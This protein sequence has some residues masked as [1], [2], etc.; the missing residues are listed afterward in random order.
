M[1]IGLKTMLGSVE[2][3]SQYKQV[4]PGYILGAVMVFVI[5]FIPTAIYDIVN[6]NGKVST[7]SSVSSDYFCPECGANL[8]NA[9]AKAS[10]GWVCPRCKKSVIPR[11]TK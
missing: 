3:K 7:S 10:T 5:T 1:I 9:P 2:E 6:S 8:G 4:L 11:S